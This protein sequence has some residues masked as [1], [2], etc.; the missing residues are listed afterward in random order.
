ME[1][2]HIDINRSLI[3]RVEATYL[4]RFSERES[5]DCIMIIDAFNIDFSAELL[6]GM[7]IVNYELK[8]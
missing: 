6:N 2:S 3:K 7:R 5:I 8:K 1:L 4:K